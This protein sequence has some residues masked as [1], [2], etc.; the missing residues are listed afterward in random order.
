M[1]L[2]L[3]WQ[4][5]DGL[6]LEDSA[7]NAIVCSNSVLVVAGPGAG[8]TELLAQKAYYL[9][10]YEKCLEP[11]RILAISFKGD[12]ADNLQKR[13]EKRCKSEKNSRFYSKTYDA[14][15][16]GILDRFRNGINEE[17]RPKANYCINE[18]KIMAEVFRKHGYSTKK[19]DMYNALDSVEIPFNGKNPYE[20]VWKALVLG[21][22]NS[23]QSVVTFKIISRLVLML[24][25]DNPLIIEAIR[26]TYSHVFLDEFQDTTDIQYSI[27]CKCF[28]GSNSQLTAVGDEKQC[29]MRWAGAMVGIFGSFCKDFASARYEL[30]MNHRSAPKLV[31][32]QKRM[33]E[34]L[35]E[36]KKEI[37]C[38]KKWKVDDGDVTLFKF[39]DT[40]TETFEVVDN[41]K[42]RVEKGIKP[43]DICILT[44]QMPEDYVTSI[45][46]E[47]DKYSIRARIETNY[48]DLIKEVIVTLLIHCIRLIIEEKCLESWDY[49]NDFIWL[50]A[51]GEY[52]NISKYEE[53]R[54]S[55]LRNMRRHKEDL[56]GCED[57][58]L[59]IEVVDDILSYFKVDRIKAVCPQYV[60]GNY[61]NERV[62]SFKEKMWLEYR[63]AN[64]K[65]SVAVDNFLGLNSIPIM[66]IHKSKGLEY[67]TVYFIGL[68]DSAF[69]NFKKQPQE[70][71]CAF[72]V[73]L[74]RAKQSIVFTFSKN[75]QLQYSSVQSHDSINE[76]YKLLENIEFVNVI[77]K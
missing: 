9:L 1:S 26:A 58:S 7:N 37:C 3:D 53:E 47:L 41:I 65:W 14:F 39:T 5:A 75:R 19:R 57:E 66:T 32:I 13:V 72:F 70:D 21:D 54:K 48:Q 44:K 71:K 60:Q 27:V 61:F 51:S 16:K 64:Y 77:E 36:T 62:E 55:V 31:E 74:S 43:S 42:Q 34:I 10:N 6:E 49:I 45:I 59:F 38:N 50:I 12:A 35:G 40:N 4:P 73:A 52:E 33:Y 63:L 11:N 23:N 15:A 30:L 76:F 24:L 29:I 8:K 25:T 46:A 56:N 68:E 18:E 20:N 17:Y 22:N 28:K 67:N 69:W 2:D